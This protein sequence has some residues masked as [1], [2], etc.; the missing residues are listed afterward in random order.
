MPDEIAEELEENESSCS[1]RFRYLT[2]KL[3]HF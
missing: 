1:E 3:A 2:V